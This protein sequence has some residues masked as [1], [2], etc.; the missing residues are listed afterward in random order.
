MP[1]EKRRRLDVQLV[2]ISKVGRDGDMDSVW[3]V[4]K[5]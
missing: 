4:Q 3:R 5:R 1:L 2:S